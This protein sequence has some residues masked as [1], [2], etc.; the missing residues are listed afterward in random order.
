MIVMDEDTCMV[1]VARYFL[2]FTQQES[3]G[4]C[5]P[6]RLGTKQMVEVLNRITQGQGVDGD[7]EFLR[8]IGKNI[9]AASLCGLG[10]TAPNPVMTTIQ[11][12]SEEYEAHIKKKTCP[13]CVCKALVSYVIDPDLCSG[14]VVCLKNCPAGAISGKPKKVHHIDQ[15]KCTK[16]GICMAVCPPK[17]RA[18][19]KVSPAIS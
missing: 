7:I 15:S 14:C 8:W 1:D 4:K 18:V 16:C 10:Q 6:C 3:C 19:K 17:F 11:Y 9:K 12:F 13:A 5:V 2:N